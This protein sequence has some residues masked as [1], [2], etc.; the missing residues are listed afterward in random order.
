[1]KIKH[2]IVTYNNEKVLNDCLKSLLPTFEKY[3]KDEYQLYVINNH[4]NF[5]IDDKFNQYVTILHNTL[6]PDF[7]TGHL[8]RNWN[9]AIINGFQNLNTPDC[10]YVILSQNDCV[11][12]SNFIEKLIHY[13]NRY[14]FIQLGI[15]DEVMSITPNAVKRIGLF[16][17][18]FCNIGFQ[19]ADYFIRALILLTDKISIN[20]LFHK[21]V[22]NGIDTS[23]LI[24]NSVTGFLRGDIDHMKSFKYHKITKELFIKKWGFDPEYCDNWSYESFKNLKPLINSF[25]LYPYFENEIEIETFKKLNY[26]IY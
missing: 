26:I 24:K 1:M 17:E 6:R 16:D 20:D 2:Y 10:D 15:G 21:R 9:Q 12:Q 13:H 11:F 3:S 14:D 8:S 25:I 7:S 23:L 19:E 18:R 5:S 22:W 4:S